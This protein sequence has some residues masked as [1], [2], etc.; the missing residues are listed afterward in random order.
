MPPSRR[1]TK[2]WRSQSPSSPITYYRPPITVFLIANRS[3]LEFAAT[4]RKHT[5]A[6]FSNRSKIGHPCGTTTPSDPWESS[7]PSAFYSRST[8]PLSRWL[9]TTTPAAYAPAK[10]AP[11]GTAEKLI[12][13]Y[14]AAQVRLMPFVSGVSFGNALAL[15][16]ADLK[17]PG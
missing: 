4:Q 7:G 8:S 11:L 1:R 6:V 5:D 15:L 9:K 2:S 17:I 14:V 10:P 3:G 16:L 12:L 13:L